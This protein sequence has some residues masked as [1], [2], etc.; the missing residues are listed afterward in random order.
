MCSEGEPRGHTGPPPIG[1]SEDE[2]LRLAFEA[3]A[4]DGGA[5]LQLVEH[6]AGTREAATKTTGSWPSWAA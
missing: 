2:I 1:R 4:R 3:A 6:T 5:S